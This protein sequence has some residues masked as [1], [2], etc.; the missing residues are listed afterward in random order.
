[1]ALKHQHLC[2]KDCLIAQW[3]VNRHLVTIEVGVERCT[4][5]WVELN[6]LTL[7]KL[8][9]ECLDR[10]TVKC[11]GTVKHNRMTLH[12]VLK[13]IPDN[14]LTTVY[15]LL[16]ALYSLHDTA[17]NELTD[18]KWL[19]ELGSHKLWQTNLAHIELRTYD[20]NRTT[21]VVNTLTEQVLTET[22]LLTLQRVRE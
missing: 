16:S 18:D 7:D 8:R 1:M 10:Q 2:F 19:I 17:L 5:Q 9:L 15:Y 4:C 12:H 6:S 3:Q 11:R 20:D 14:R 21:R 13:D 22:S